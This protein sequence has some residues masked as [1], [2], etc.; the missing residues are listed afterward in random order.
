MG[1]GVTHRIVV[2]GAGPAGIRCAEAIVAA[3]LRPTVID[4]GTRSGGQIYRRQPE[5]FTRSYD[6]LYG[7]EARQAEALHRSFDNLLQKIDYFPGTLIWNVADKCVHTV[8]GSTQRELPYDVLILCTGATDR[9]MAVKG[10]NLAGAFSLG[11]AQIALK[12]QACAIGRVVVFAGTGPL[13]YLVAGQY[14]KAGATVAAVVDTSPWLARLL[15][16]PGLSACPSMLWKGISLTTDLYRAGIPLYAGGQLLEID[17]TPNDGVAGLKFRD[18]RG[19]T[20]YIA[21]D[22]VALGYHLRSEL[23]LADLARCEFRFDKQTR[24]WLPYID[25]DGRSTVPDVY[26]AGD[27]ARILGADAAET[28]GRLAGLAALK[29]LDHTT[30]M[31]EVKYL[32][33]RLVRFRR[34]A[35]GLNRAFRWPASQAAELPDDTVVCRCESVRAGEIRRVVQQFGAFEL[36]RVKAFSRIGMGRCQGRYCGNT[37]AEIV[38]HCSR[39]P[40]EQVGRLRSQAPVKPIAISLASDH[41]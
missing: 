40:I 27:G 17:G 2:V 18:G 31:A 20:R 16:L 37:A 33:R 7:T 28:A 41:E 3:G 24:Q 38:A 22:A 11:G 1:P 15:A 26:L 4:E 19:R 5:N 29:D 9:L 10:W 39:T 36:N 34:F 14:A 21:C 23:Q 12:S 8:T 6:S 35:K 13:L 32:R 25:K 30:S